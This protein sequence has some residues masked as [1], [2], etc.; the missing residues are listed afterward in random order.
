M[1]EE[2]ALVVESGNTAIE[3]DEA[4]SLGPSLGPP[5]GSQIKPNM[6]SIDTALIKPGGGMGFGRQVSEYEGPVTS[7]LETQTFGEPDLEPIDEF[8]K[9]VE[10]LSARDARTSRKESQ[11][12]TARVHS[13][14]PDEAKVSA[15][16][17]VAALVDSESKIDFLD[18]VGADA[19]IFAE[20]T[21]DEKSGGVD[22]A[23]QAESAVSTQ[24]ESK[25]PA[26]KVDTGDKSAEARASAKADTKSAGVESPSV[27]IDAESKGP[28]AENAD[29]ESSSAKQENAE[30]ASD[31]EVDARASYRTEAKMDVD[32]KQ[33]AEIRT[34]GEVKENGS[35]ADPPAQAA[36]QKSS[37]LS[38]AG[39][40][41]E[42]ARVQSEQSPEPAKQPTQSSRGSDKENVESKG[43]VPTSAGDA[44]AK[45]VSSPRPT[46]P[47]AASG[48][49]A[50]FGQVAEQKE[51]SKPSQSSKQDSADSR[52]QAESKAAESEAKQVDK[53]DSKREI[54]AESESAPFVRPVSNTESSYEVGY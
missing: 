33:A 27:S 46:S 5:P 47:R 18:D 14:D 41:S 17:P 29:A 45:V 52:S 50:A 16:E 2:A 48:K 32:S 11:K 34:D 8:P 9:V 53:A 35:A 7:E 38:N 54:A 20:S 26:E 37:K 4:I 6:L 44:E 21:V 30:V 40:E 36:S 12:S 23:K 24:T 31:K 19:K 51:S 10:I 15:K 42:S 3:A 49:T 13:P 28:A 25:A 1:E 43:D 22:D 39:Q